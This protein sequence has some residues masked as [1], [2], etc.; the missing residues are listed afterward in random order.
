MKALFILYL[1]TSFLVIIE[2]IIR[3]Y[4]SFF[5]LNQNE[6]IET[7]ETKTESKEIVYTWEKTK[8]GFDT[9]KTIVSEF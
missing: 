9:R 5:Q 6:T 3:V 1:I 8:D 4:F 2:H 7:I